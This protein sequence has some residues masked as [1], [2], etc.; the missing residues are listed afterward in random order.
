ME[1]NFHFN[2]IET[3][4]H[5]HTIEFTQEEILVLDMMRY[6]LGSLVLAKLLGFTEKKVD[7]I[8]KNVYR[9]AGCADLQELLL[10]LDV[11]KMAI[12]NRKRTFG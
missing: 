6:Q 1:P 4:E 10:Y 7:T 5:V 3:E 12:K 8:K 11:Y 9:K 2:K